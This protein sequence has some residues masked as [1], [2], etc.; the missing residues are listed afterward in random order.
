MAL[1]PKAGMKLCNVG[2][3]VVGLQHIAT[4]RN[5]ANLEKRIS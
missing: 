1:S 5:K 2:A 3:F 4:D